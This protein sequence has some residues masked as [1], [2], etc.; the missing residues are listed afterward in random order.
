MGKIKQK[1]LH[2]KGPRIKICILHEGALWYENLIL[3]DWMT[4]G[5][6]GSSS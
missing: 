4:H 6:M 2:L 5:L 1:P 3:Y